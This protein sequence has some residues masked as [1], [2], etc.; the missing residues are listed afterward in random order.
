MTELHSQDNVFHFLS[1]DN[2][3]NEVIKLANFSNILC[4]AFH[5][6]YLG[7]SLGEKWQ[8]QGLMH[9]V[10]V[11]TIRYMQ[12]HQGVH[13]IMASHMPRN[14]RSGSLLV[15]LCFEREGYAKQYLQI[16]GE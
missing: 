16:D 12:K 2:Q 10:L 5:A 13:R 1:L 3:E 11:Q 14:L 15:R 7:Y 6:C 4:G 8:G 9:E